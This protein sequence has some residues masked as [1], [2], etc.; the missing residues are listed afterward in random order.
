MWGV[1][2][3][4]QVNFRAKLGNLLNI[5]LSKILPKVHFSGGSVFLSR[6]KLSKERRL[7]GSLTKIDFC[8]KSEFLFQKWIWIS[9]VGM[10]TF[11]G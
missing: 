5:H 3:E 2:I 4:D 8:T 9:R 6:K 7:I 10:D 1:Y 11:L